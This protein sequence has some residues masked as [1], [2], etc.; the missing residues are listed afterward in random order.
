METSQAQFRLQGRRQGKVLCS[1]T[2]ISQ[3]NSS[4]V[5]RLCIY[6]ALSPVPGD[7]ELRH[8]DRYFPREAVRV[9]AV[10]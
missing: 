7:I 10:R 8:I 6:I 3:G 2:G 1:A 5:A 4:C 9:Y